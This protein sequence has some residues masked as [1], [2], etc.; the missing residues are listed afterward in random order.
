MVDLSAN[1]RFKKWL[2][3][4]QS[5]RVTQR[6]T[7]K[8]YLIAP[9]PKRKLTKSHREGRNVRRTDQE[10]IQVSSQ[11]NSPQQTPPSCMLVQPC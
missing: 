2:L 11:H 8:V 1:T 6:A 7:R 5:H 4:F 3:L 9:A 10:M